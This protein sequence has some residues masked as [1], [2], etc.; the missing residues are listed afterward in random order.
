MS[1]FADVDVDLEGLESLAA[2]EVI[3]A[4]TMGEI[5]REGFVNGWQ[6]RGYVT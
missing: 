1:Y 4:P 3:Q 6:E 5:S 2:N